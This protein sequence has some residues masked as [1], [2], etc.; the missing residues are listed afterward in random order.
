[1]KKKLQSR[2]RKGVPVP[3][4]SMGD[5][6][7]L[8]IIF[9]MVC[10]KISKDNSNV[11]VVLPWSQFVEENE[12]QVVARVAIDEDGQIFLDGFVVESAK[13]VEWGLRALLADTVSNDQRMV[14]FKA[15]ANLPKE[16]FE[17]VLEA[18]TTAGGQLMAVGEDT[19]QQ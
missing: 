18:I 7:F 9:F 10:S 15:D 16:Q 8:L 12:D 4:A 5:I 1:M 3:I 2:K 14:Q 19:P 6:A 11:N 13:D 17:P